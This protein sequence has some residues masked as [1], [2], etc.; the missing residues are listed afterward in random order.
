MAPDEDPPAPP[1]AEDTSPPPAEALEPPEERRLAGSPH[2]T[3]ANAAVLALTRAARSFTLYDPANKV[4]RALIAEFRDRFRAVL[5]GFGPLVLD[6][7]PFELSLGR[8]VVY[9][10]RDRERSLA[11]RL[12]R[13]GVRRLGFAADTSWEELLRL[14][15]IL[16]IRYTGVRQQE[17]DLVTLL[18]KA[19][20]DG[21]HVAAIE[22][23]VPEEEQRE[24]PLD[25]DLLRGT[26]ARYDAPLQW[27]LPLPPFPEAVALRHRAVSPELLERLRAEEA[28]D[29]V[30]KQ[31]LRA[32]AE[33]LQQTSR[34]DLAAVLGFALEVREYLL[35]EQRSDLLVELAGLVRSALAGA[36]DAAGA[37]LESW[38]DARTLRMLVSTLRPDETEVPPHLADLLDA[39]PGP[40]LD[41]LIDLLVEEG[42]GPRAPLLRR[43][44]VRGCRHA[45]GTIATRLHGA[46]GA[47]AVAL[48]RLLAE[49]D[50]AAA[51]HAA[52]EATAAT[53]PLLQRE[54]LRQ[55]EGAAFSPE[56][57]RGLHHLVESRH[58]AVR[59]AAL[60]VMAARGGP[61]V[62][63]ALRS[64]VEKH[65]ARLSAA[66]AEAAGQA[67]A[68]SSARSAAET[69]G[70]WLRPKGGGLLGKLVKM[71]APPVLQRVALAGLRGVAVADAEPLL[72]LLAEHG[73]AGLRPDARAALAARPRGGSRG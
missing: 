27:D 58:E 33:L 18:R 26:R 59:L 23:F 35:V 10:E 54:A 48:L 56:V 42:D 34:A 69:F 20:F 44:V 19:G 57:A 53:D 71:A 43:L 68:R 22:G 13:D 66:E 17:D 73:E 52:V 30:P 62:F 63:A 50:P 55:L 16:S 49:V 45:P 31:A 1:A 37:F 60:P 12:F 2:A 29:R 32:V 47:P 7:H 24:G 25:A 67:L 8:E 5:E 65:A 4:V 15:Q 39:A 6:V 38:L 41:R 70:E 21:I 28:E 61:R 64:H 51:L 11:F 46:T 14:L 3:A 40:S 72:T 9:L 36:P